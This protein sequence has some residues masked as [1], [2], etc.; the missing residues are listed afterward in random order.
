MVIEN[1]GLMI[2]YI[3]LIIFMMDKQLDMQILMYMHYLFFLQMN[4][5]IQDYILNQI[6]QQ[7]IKIDYKKKGYNQ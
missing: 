7:Q 5:T 2:F 1:I 3:M 6:F 4:K